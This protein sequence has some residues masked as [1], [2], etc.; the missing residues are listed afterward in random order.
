[1]CKDVT[2]EKVFFVSKKGRK[3][4]TNAYTC[5]IEIINKKNKQRNKH[6]HKKKNV[7][8]RVI[9]IKIKT[10]QKFVYSLNSLYKTF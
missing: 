3:K 1:M 5:V 9:K 10:K 8:T 6:T 7:Q 2:R 4:L